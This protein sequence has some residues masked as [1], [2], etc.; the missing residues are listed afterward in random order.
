LKSDKI[1]EYCKT[2]KSFTELKELTG[3]SDA[4]LYKALN[5]FLEEG[6]IRKTE[7]GKYVTTDKGEKAYNNQLKSLME[8]G[9]WMEYYGIG[10]DKIREILKILKSVKGEF[11]LKASSSS[12]ES[13]LEQLIILQELNR[14]E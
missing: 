6:L 1:L 7:E 13:L 3:L 9:I 14:D 10:E 2:P 12:D 4:G 11:Y 5:K 8:E